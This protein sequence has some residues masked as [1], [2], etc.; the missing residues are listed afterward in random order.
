MPEEVAGAAPESLQALGRGSSAPA[1]GGVNAS[2]AT[3]T[4]AC[5]PDCSA[6]GSSP[7]GVGHHF[8]ASVSPRGVQ[9]RAWMV[10]RRNESCRAAIRS[11]LMACCT[12]AKFLASCNSCS[13]CASLLLVGAGECGL[14][15]RGVVLPTAT[16]SAVDTCGG[17]NGQPLGLCDIAKVGSA[18][19]LIGSGMFTCGTVPAHTMCRT[20]GGRHPPAVSIADGDAA[21]IVGDPPV[22]QG[23]L[24]VG[25]A[26]PAGSPERRKATGLGR[27]EATRSCTRCES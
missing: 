15:D 6:S 23:T 16:T 2:V 7:L 3:S 24:A 18:V 27:G 11:L 17:G 12:A 19:L 13:C 14:C 8:N 25:N 4:R 26:K 10:S 1:L 20:G 5:R 22:T 21:L 9:C